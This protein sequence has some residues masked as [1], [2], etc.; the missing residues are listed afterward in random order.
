[1][2]ETKTC[3]R[4]KGRGKLPTPN[5]LR[6]TR[7]AAGI[8]LGQMARRMGVATPYL[9]RVERVGPVS[10]RVA[11]AYEAIEGAGA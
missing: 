3:N 10:A 5:S 11:D 8:S 4:C 9:S 6:V 2:M 7:E 1:M